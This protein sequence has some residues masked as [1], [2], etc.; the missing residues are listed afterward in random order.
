MWRSST[1]CPRWGG[2]HTHLVPEYKGLKKSRVMLEAYQVMATIPQQPGSGRELH[3][4]P[5]PLGNWGE[6]QVGAAE[7][8]DVGH[9]VQEQ[10]SFP[11][12]LPLSQFMTLLFPRVNCKLPYLA[13]TE[14]RAPLTFLI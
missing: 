1:Q 2:Y 6:G 13:L 8:V 5:R 9:Q 4:S 10:I 7:R 11:P 14:D 12:F 3:W